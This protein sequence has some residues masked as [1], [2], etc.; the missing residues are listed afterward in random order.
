MTNINTVERYA[1]L[2]NQRA[3]LKDELVA[4]EAKLDEL[5]P[6]VLAY[7]EAHSL[8]K[9]TSAG[10][11][12]YLRMETY[13]G[14]ADGVTP[15]ELTIALDNAGLSEFAERAPR[16]QQL[17]A[18]VRELQRNGKEIPDEL[19]GVLIVNVVAKIGSRRS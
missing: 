8:D 3:E 15:E 5:R 11:T 18:Y 19:K 9:L 6:G 12:L 13:A 16:M 2:E 10:R 14:R 17:S 7:F 4:V 1:K